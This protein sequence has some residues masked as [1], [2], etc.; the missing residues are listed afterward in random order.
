M[1]LRFNFVKSYLLGSVG[2]LSFIG[3]ASL[4][5]GVGAVLSM[6]PVI[7]RFAFQAYE[8]FIT[9][10]LCFIGFLASIH[11]GFSAIRA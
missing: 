10:K 4:V 5:N 3:C 9:N 11:G 1:L 8:N 2:D 6:Y 7:C